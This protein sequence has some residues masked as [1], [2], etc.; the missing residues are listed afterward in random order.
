MEL[1]FETAPHMQR[2]NST[3]RIMMHLTIALL[4]VYV[5]ALYRA[6]SLGT[7]YLLNA[8]L[9]MLASNVTAILTECVWA[10]CRHIKIKEQLESSFPWVTAII[11][12]LMVQVNTEVYAIVVATF[13]AIFFGKLV[14]GG[15]GQNIFNPAAVGR[16]IIFASF[17]GN[18]SVDLITSATPASTLAAVGQIATPSDF[19]IFLNDFGGLGNLALGLYQGAMGETSSLLILALGVY[20]TLMDV[21]D[22]RIPVTYLGVIFVGSFLVALPH[23]LGFDYALYAVLTGG[24]VFGA[25]FMLTD[26]VTSPTTRAGKMVYAALTALITVII[27][28]Y[29]NLPE[30]VLYSILFGNILTPVIDKYFA[31]KQVEHLNKINIS[32]ITVVLASVVLIGV[33]GLGLDAKAYRSINIADFNSSGTLTLAGNYEP[34]GAKVEL[35]DEGSYRVTVTG[36]GMLDSESGGGGGSHGDYVYSENV[37][38][39][40]IE[41]GKVKDIKLVNFGDTPGIGDNALDALL[42]SFIGKSATDSV[43]FVSGATYTSKSVVAAVQAAFEAAGE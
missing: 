1:K 27:R 38:D 4:I 35:N 29:S 19:A 36:Y 33:L 25:V 24:A 15:F 9:L 30:G 28:Y 34:Q 17:A 37:F 20:L 39:I 26:P 2:K 8:I 13:I 6:Y 21:I 7:A 42:Q 32:V 10:K 41:D 5:F 23:G 11:L 3:G 16:A 43:D 31:G 40:W 14:F 18:I 22:W 12:T